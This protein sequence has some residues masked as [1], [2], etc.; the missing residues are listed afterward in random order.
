MG[1]SSDP[2]VANLLC[3]VGEGWA[4]WLSSDPG[5]E[6]LLGLDSEPLKFHQLFGQPDECGRPRKL[7]G[8]RSLTPSKI[9]VRFVSPNYHPRRGPLF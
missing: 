6:L 1:K 7:A 8:R 5:L 2:H 9:G 3:Q 4:F